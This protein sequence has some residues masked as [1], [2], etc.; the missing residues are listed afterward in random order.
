VYVFWQG[1]FGGPDGLSAH[2]DDTLLS[3]GN[4]YRLNPN[5][6]HTDTY[7]VPSQGVIIR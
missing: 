7:A 5:A 1:N 6:D 2:L 3:L 4:P